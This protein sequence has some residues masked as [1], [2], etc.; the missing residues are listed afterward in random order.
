MNFPLKIISNKK[1]KTQL[2]NQF[3]EGQKDILQT[4]FSSSN[5]AGYYNNYITYDDQVN[6]LYLMYYGKSTLG[7]ETT[8]TA[9]D[10]RTVLISGEGVSVIAKRKSTLKWINEFLKT[11][12]L[13]STKLLQLVTHGELEGRQLIAIEPN[14]EK[15][16]FNL[17]QILYKDYKYLIKTDDKDKQKIIKITVQ[18]K[19]GTESALPIGK[20]IYVKLGGSIEDF[21]NTPSKTASV[22]Q[23]IKNLDRALY[24][25]RQSNHHFGFPT[26]AF[27][28]PDNES[29]KQT[30][31]M[32][33]KTK[34]QVGSTICS[35]GKLYYPQ[36]P[37][38]YQ[39]LE[40]EIAL[41][42][43]VISSR[44]GIPVHWL[45]WTDLMSNRAVSHDLNELIQ[46]GTKAER[47]I[48]AESIK[49]IILKAMQLSID[50]GFGN[51]PKS[52]DED[53]EVELPYIS[54]EYIDRLNTTWLPLQ[55][56]G[57][58]AMSQFRN[59]IPGINPQETEE[60]VQAEKKQ[61]ID[62]NRE[63]IE[64]NP[65]E[66]QEENDNEY[67]EN[68]NIKGKNNGKI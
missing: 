64:D 21:N 19:D 2:Q 53:F 52:F 65:E 34:W 68:E 15:E 35:T 47:L 1:Y 45:G 17:R 54:L 30:F 44:I 57:A 49:E 31:N 4:P 59:K 40:S 42:I 48:W 16:T 6:E 51:A 50:E 60:L 20:L 55:M 39:V 8:G 5:E 56:Q 27:E 28:C 61:A 46:A 37:A 43:K 66:N 26:P 22:I 38:S 41:N 9:I 25:L 10:L 23:N 58:I 32:V 13:N 12:K 63:M 36:P 3:L 67:K 29:V 62:E 7:S 24:D 11:S 18:N 14:R 33:E